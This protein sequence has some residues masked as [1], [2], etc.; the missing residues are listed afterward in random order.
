M[1][2]HKMYIYI[3]VFEID[4]KWKKKTKSA[5]RVKSADDNKI[6]MR[7]GGG[8]CALYICTKVLKVQALS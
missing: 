2:Q 8:V 7:C 1:S 3:T 4:E 5:Y 6:G